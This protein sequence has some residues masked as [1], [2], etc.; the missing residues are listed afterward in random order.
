[1]KRICSLPS[2]TN[3][4]S[5]KTQ[6]QIANFVSSLISGA[7]GFQILNSGYPDVPAGRTL[8]LTLWTATRALDVLIGELWSRRKKRRLRSGRWSGVEEGVGKLADVLAFSL[9]AGT[10]MFAWCYLPEKLPR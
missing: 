6:K 9:A 7:A 2:C 3:S 5:A 1:M 8:D 10:V 4:A